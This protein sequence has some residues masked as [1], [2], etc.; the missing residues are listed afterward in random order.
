MAF[1]ARPLTSRALR[2]RGF[3]ESAI[4]HK[5]NTIVGEHIAGWCVPHRLAFGKGTQGGTLHL[6]VPGARAP[7]LQHLE[8]ILLE[9]INMVFGYPAVARI[10]LLQGS[11]PPP[12]EARL[13][14]LRPLESAEQLWISEQ[15]EQIQSPDLKAALESLGRMVLAGN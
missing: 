5:W 8:P 14:T 3:V 9:R 11:V 12:S 4:I 6:L 2:R 13:R 10:A 15:V 7:E 1:A